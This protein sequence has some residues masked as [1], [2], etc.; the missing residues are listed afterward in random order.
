MVYTCIKQVSRSHLVLGSAHISL[1]FWCHFLLCNYAEVLVKWEAMR[2]NSCLARM[3]AYLEV[4][5]S[6]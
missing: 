6:K 3:I 4:G 1:Q 5:E 2:K